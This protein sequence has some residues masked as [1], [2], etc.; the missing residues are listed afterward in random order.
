MAEIERRTLMGSLRIVVLALAALIGSSMVIGKASAMP[1]NG[2][3]AV[4]K[5]ISHDVQDVRW[6]CWPFQCW[7]GPHHYWGHRYWGHRY[8]G[9]RYWGH[10]Y[11]GRPYWGPRPYYGWGWHRWG[12]HHRWGLHHRWHRHV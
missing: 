7:W 8:W 10:R 6:V 3:P 4:S 2:L 1:A 5:Q 12:W 11:W 9:H